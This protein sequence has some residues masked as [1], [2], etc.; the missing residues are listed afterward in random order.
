MDPRVVRTEPSADPD[1]FLKI[2][3][4]RGGAGRRC[5]CTNDGEA[6]DQQH[7]QVTCQLWDREALDEP[8]IARG[9][10]GRRRLIA[11]KW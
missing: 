3:H 8:G 11:P 5:G 6:I 10:A 4:G 9:A 7:K 1:W 2:L